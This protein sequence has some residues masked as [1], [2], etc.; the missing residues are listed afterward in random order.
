MERVGLLVVHG[1]GDQNRG[2]HVQNVAESFVKALVLQYGNDKISVE[3]PGLNGDL[4][5]HLRDDNREAT[6][7]LVEMWWRDLGHQPRLSALIGFWLWAVSL[8]GTRGLFRSAAQ[9]RKNP[10]NPSAI[11]SM[12]LPY[13]RLLL[14]LKTTYFFLLLSPIAMV[15]RLITIIPGVRQIP[16]IR[17]VFTYLSSVQLY[18]ERRSTQPGT[19]VD[20][21]QSRRM[22]IQ[23]RLANLIVSMS[24]P[25]YDRWYIWVIV[26]VR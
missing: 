11:H 7:D 5:I 21:D 6:F 10:E 19:L 17:S 20:Y 23:R 16:F 15:V 4:T 8:P 1:I 18:Q 3:L 24:E 2:Q 25:D 26:W 14:L 9:G 13:D 12:V 22:S